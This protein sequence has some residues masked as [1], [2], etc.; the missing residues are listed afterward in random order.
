MAAIYELKGTANGQYMFNLK[1]GNGEIILTSELY[2][3]KEAAL[4]GIE[5]VKENAP[6][7]AQYE[8]KES[9]R[10]EPYF[11]LKA[12]NHQVIGKSEMYSSASSRDNGIESVKKNGPVATLKDIS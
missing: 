2:K 8:R 1:A 11:V 10:A 4:N 9:A 7:D 6:I 5:S 12:K 3:T